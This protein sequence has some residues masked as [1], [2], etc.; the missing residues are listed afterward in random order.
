MVFFNKNRKQKSVVNLSRYLRTNE[1]ASQFIRFY[2]KGN[3]D[4]Q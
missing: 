1:H 4:L 2:M 3:I